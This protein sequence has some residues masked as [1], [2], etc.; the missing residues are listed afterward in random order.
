[1]TD[2]KSYLV[3][4]VL[5]LVFLFFFIAVWLAS[6]EITSFLSLSKTNPRPQCY[7]CHPVLS[8]RPLHIK[9]KADRVRCVLLFFLLCFVFILVCSCS[10]AIPIFLYRTFKGFID[11]YCQTSAPP[12]KLKLYG[13]TTFF[14]SPRASMKALM[15]LF[16]SSSC[17]LL[18]Q[19]VCSLFIMDIFILL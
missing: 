1:M 13:L 14:P 7:P 12:K 18:T 17:Y 5:G 11:Y 10:V 15:E 2:L 16:T 4:V 6:R 3:L 9:N 19:G 8:R